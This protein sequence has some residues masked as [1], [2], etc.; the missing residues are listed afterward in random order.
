LSERDRINQFDGLRAFAFLAVFLHHG[1]HAPLLW[2]GVD[3]F[4]VL[5]GF[6][7]TRNLIGL[8]DSATAGSALGA[9]YFRRVLRI[10]PPYYLALAMIMVV[11]PIALGET[12]W[13]LAFGSNIR[14]AIHGPIG[15]AYDSMWSIAVEEQFYIVWPWLVLFVSRRHLTKL[16]VVVI[17]AAP[18]CRLLFSSVGFDAVYRL[19]PSRMDLLALGAVLAT[20]DVRDPSWFERNRRPMLVV[21]AIA[22]ALFAALSVSLPTFRTSLNGVLFDVVGFGLSAVFFTA[23]LAFVRGS[24]QGVVYAVL[25]SPALRY[26]GAISYMAYLTHMLGLELAHHAHLGKWGEAAL[27][28]AITLA[29][30]SASWF[31]VEKP[32][33]RLRGLV[34]PR[35]NA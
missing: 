19:T 35:S 7:I 27:G 22:V 2:M 28:L 17:L 14:D 29:L 23:I 20:V 13:F 5:S 18:L 34:K 21:A 10:L 25:T 32:L 3:Q 4:F 15:G 6:L 16:F 1:V 8:R 33:Q 30:S 31:L 9:F 24:T 12:P 26:V 11:R